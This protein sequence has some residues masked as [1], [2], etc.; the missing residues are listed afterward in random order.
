MPWS[1]VIEHRHTAGGS[2]IRI[3]SAWCRMSPSRGWQV[4]QSDQSG[5]PL[6]ERADG[7]ALILAEDQMAFPTALFGSV[8]GREG[9][10]VDGEH[11]VLKPGPARKLCRDRPRVQ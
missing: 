8:L 2:A 7:R 9:T 5:L 4:Q 1:Q 6:D 11:W 10:L 3:F